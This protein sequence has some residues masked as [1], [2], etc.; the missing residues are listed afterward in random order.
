MVEPLAEPDDV[1][2][3]AEGE[4]EPHPVDPLVGDEPLDRAADQTGV[5]TGERRGQ[6]LGE[7]GDP[8]GRGHGIPLGG[9]RHAVPGDRVEAVTVAGGLLDGRGLD[10]PAA[11]AAEGGGLRRGEVALAT[12]E[13][14]GIGR[15]GDAGLEDQGGG[16]ATGGHPLAG[17]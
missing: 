1:V 10:G 17:H 16:V 2:T 14:G 7:V 12:R 3:L 13:C 5:G 8:P 11:V 6:S 4:G 9:L 15:V